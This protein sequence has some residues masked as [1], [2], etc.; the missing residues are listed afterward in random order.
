MFLLEIPIYRFPELGSLSDGRAHTDYTSD[1]HGLMRKDNGQDICGS[2]TDRQSCFPRSPAAGSVFSLLCRRRYG[3]L[4]CPLNLYNASYPG[5]VTHFG[6]FLRTS[7]FI[8]AS[9]KIGFAVIS[10]HR[11]A[12]LLRDGGSG[13]EPRSRTAALGRAA[14]IPAFRGL[15]VERVCGDYDFTFV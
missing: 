6:K 11:A 14:Y 5:R 12:A 13:Y 2:L 8:T 15:S 9:A 10:A 7:Y 4:V 1:F 3:R